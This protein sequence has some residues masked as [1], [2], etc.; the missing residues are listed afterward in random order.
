MNKAFTQL[1]YANTY[2]AYMK[3][4]NSAEST[5]EHVFAHGEFCGLYNLIVSAGLENA[6]YEWRECIAERD[7]K[8]D[9]LK[10]TIKNLHQAGSLVEAENRNLSA[11]V[12]DLQK[13]LGHDGPVSGHVKKES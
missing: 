8:M 5:D 11:I 2:F 10:E 1:L 7:I 4:I 3:Y 12:D 6:Y 13:Q 9:E